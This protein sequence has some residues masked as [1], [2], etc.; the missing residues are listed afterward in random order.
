MSKKI[1]SEKHIILIISLILAG[2]LGVLGFALAESC[3]NKTTVK[4]TTVTFVGELTDMGGDDVTYVWFEYGKTTSLSKKTSEKSLTQEGLYCITVSG[5]EPATT[6][7]YR[8]AARNSVGT[9]YGEIKSFTTSIASENGNFTVEKTVRNLSDGTNYL[10]SVSTD[11]KE[12]LIFRI[13]VKAENESLSDVIVKDTLP[14]GL[15]YLGELKINNVSVSGNILTGLNIGDFSAG[16]E[17]V[18]TFQVNV[19]GPESFAFGQTELKNRVLVS[20]DDFSRSDIAEVVVSRA[21]VA[22]AVTEI[23]TG[24]TNNIFFDSLFLPF[25]IALVVIYLFKSRIIKFEEWLDE[26]KK[27]YREYY[28]NK[29]LRLKI[30]RIRIEEFFKKKLF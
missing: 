16:E 11:P 27:K 22:G 29:I 18:I 7:Y 3:P 28:S 4:G 17:K 15:T 6:Y 24:L 26:R 20:T 30:S 9:S 12:V 10:K 19:L 21:A 1:I 23:A 13:K 25:I 14:N 8:A 2:V 5:L